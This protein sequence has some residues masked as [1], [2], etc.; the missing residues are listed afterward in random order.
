MNDC[1]ERNFDQ[2]ISRVNL[3]NKLLIYELYYKMQ[4]AA[5]HVTKSNEEA[6]SIT[7]QIFQER[8]SIPFEMPR[9]ATTT[10]TTDFIISICCVCDKLHRRNDVRR[11]QQC[12]NVFHNRCHPN[13]T[14]CPKCLAGDGPIDIVLTKLS[15]SWWP[16]IIVHNHQVPANIYRKRKNQP[17]SVFV[18]IIGNPKN[19]YEQVHA[20]N[21]LTFRNDDAQ[22]KLLNLKNNKNPQLEAAVKIAETLRLGMHPRQALDSWQQSIWLK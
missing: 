9:R 21:F 22:E 11:C 16:A 12:A 13:R 7:T 5:R 10:T 20:S 14:E 2:V 1:R 4:R 6:Q 8:H 3:K 15:K 17:G 18:F 19:S